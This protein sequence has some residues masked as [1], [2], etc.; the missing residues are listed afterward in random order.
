MHRRVSPATMPV[1]C[2]YF[3]NDCYK[4]NRPPRNRENAYSVANTCIS[5]LREKMKCS[6]HAAVYFALHTVGLQHIKKPFS[7]SA[8]EFGFSCSSG[9]H[10]HIR[11]RLY[12]QTKLDIAIEYDVRMHSLP[13]HHFLLSPTQRREIE[14]RFAAHACIY[15]AV[16]KSTRIVPLDQ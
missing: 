2:L 1:H 9:T 15:I 7:L 3:D 14:F 5:G 11:V 16:R 6:S 4:F 13:I 8:V 12:V 10:S